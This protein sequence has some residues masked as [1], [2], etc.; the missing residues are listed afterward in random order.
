[1]ITALPDDVNI[2]RFWTITSERVEQKTRNP[3][4]WDC[5]FG[6]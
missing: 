1:M 4:T 5:R 3:V 6:E 2:K